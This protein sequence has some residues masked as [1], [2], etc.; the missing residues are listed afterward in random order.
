MGPRAPDGERASCT[1]HLGAADRDGTVVALTQTLLSP[2]GAKVMLSQTGIL[3]NNGIMW[4]DPRPGGPNS[5]APG[6]RRFPTCARPSS[7][8]RT[9]DARHSAP[10]AGAASSPP[11][12]SYSPSSRISA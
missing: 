8:S 5:I 3:L 7:S 12:R 4:F 6:K 10:P 9:A 2:F 1:S 11:S